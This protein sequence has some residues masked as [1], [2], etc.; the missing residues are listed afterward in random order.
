MVEKLKLEQLGRVDVETFKSL[1]KIPT[2]IVLDNI[3]SMHNVDRK[4][5]V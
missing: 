4:S 3:R 1:E 5:V 2:I